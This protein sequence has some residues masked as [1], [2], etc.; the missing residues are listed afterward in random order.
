MC[1][2]VQKVTSLLFRGDILNTHLCQLPAQPFGP[3][4]MCYACLIFNEWLNDLSVNWTELSGN[5]A[6]TERG[7]IWPG[8][9]LSQAEQIELSWAALSW[10]W[11][12]QS[13]FELSVNWAELRWT[14]CERVRR[15]WAEQA[16][17]FFWAVTSLIRDIN[18][19]VSSVCTLHTLFR[20]KQFLAKY[21]QVSS[22]QPTAACRTIRMH[23]AKSKKGDSL[24]QW[25]GWVSACFCKEHVIGHYRK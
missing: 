20:I 24:H 9:K 19:V 15:S 1:Y 4:L 21:L 13:W 11:V 25:I 5:W 16:H 23:Y 18:S 17:F 6:K 14:E 2:E 22:Q 8:W 10:A 7:L 3:K 12:E